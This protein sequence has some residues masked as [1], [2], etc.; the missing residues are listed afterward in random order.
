MTPP[1][2]PRI[3]PV[4]DPDEEQTALLSKTLLTED[5]TPL[6]LFAT[7]AHHPRLL[8]RFNALG[9]FFL[10]HGSVPP[11]ERELVILRVAARTGSDYEF[12]QHVVIGATAGLSGQEMARTRQ[13]L[14]EWDDEDRALL[15]FVDEVLDSEGAQVPSWDR[16]A[17]RF[18]EPVMIELALLVGF[19]RMLAGFLNAVGVEVEE[20]TRTAGDRVLS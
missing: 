11:R 14:Q 4:T 20:A 1:R 10:V 12:A 16:L 18:P 19:Y 13:P 2:G 5:G 15:E 9:G 7:L 17:A 3:A 6:N 8:K